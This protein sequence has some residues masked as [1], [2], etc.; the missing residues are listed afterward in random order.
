MVKISPNSKFLVTNWLW[1]KN[2]V[3]MGQIFPNFFFPQI[4]TIIPWNLWQTVIFL[5]RSLHEK[6][7]PQQ[8]SLDIMPYVASYATLQ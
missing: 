3:E 7:F 6:F 1:L 5:G 4:L 8:K 2:S